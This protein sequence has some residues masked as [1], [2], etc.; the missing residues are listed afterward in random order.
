MLRDTPLPV[1]EAGLDI[2]NDTPALTLVILVRGRMP[3]PLTT[4]PR[5]AEVMAASV[6]VVEF[7]V[8]LQLASVRG[9]LPKP[10]ERP[11]PSGVVAMVMWKLRRSFWAVLGVNTLMVLTRRI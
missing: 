9:L 5:S 7:W 1:A 2:T 4:M 10:P 8:V 3:V 6:T 11:M